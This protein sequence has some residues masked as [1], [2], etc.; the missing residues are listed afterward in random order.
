VDAVNLDREAEEEFW[1][2]IRRKIK[3]S[4]T[5]DE[6]SIVAPLLVPPKVKGRPSNMRSFS[7]AM[8]CHLHRGK[9][10]KSAV[11]ATME[12]FKISRKAVFVALSKWPA[13]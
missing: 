5:A 6:W 11:A 8:F 1:R 4:L 13:A 7:I 9:N 10:L 12:R 3:A 2:E